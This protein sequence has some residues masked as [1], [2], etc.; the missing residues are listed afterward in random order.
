VSWNGQCSPRGSGSCTSSLFQHNTNLK[1]QSHEIENLLDNVHL[2]GLGQW[3]WAVLW[4]RN[5]FF[6]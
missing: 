4:F 5:F 1:G 3:K 2:T 6:F